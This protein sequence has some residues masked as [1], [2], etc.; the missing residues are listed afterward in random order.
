MA[1]VKKKSLFDHI[2]QITDVQNPNYWND[3]SDDDKKSWSNYMVNRF[4]SMKMDW[5]DIVNEVQKYN[6]KPELIYKM[7]MDII[8]KG[9]YYLRYIKGKKKKNMD[10]PQWMINVVRN[11]LEV[12]KRE[13]KETIDIL[14]M[15]EGGVL[16][17]TEI[18][19]K[20]GVDSKKMKKAGLI[21]L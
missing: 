21:A 15:T 9:N 12:S 17:L 14:M 10:H 13:A 4:L 7:Y 11:D 16:E 8:P 20:Y 3:I 5:I 19:N 1:T 18:A 6:L 2:K